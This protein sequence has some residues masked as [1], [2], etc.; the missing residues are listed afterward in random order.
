MSYQY[1]DC[2]VLEIEDMTDRVKRFVF[3]FPRDQ[4]FSFRAGQF[5]MLDLP[6]ESKITNRAYSIASPP[7]LDN[8]FEL[9][10]SF[11]PEGKGT[12]YL[13]NEVREGMFVKA[14]KPLG[15]F[16]LPETLNQEI[17]FICTG[18]GIAP[19]RSMLMDLYSKKIKHQGL[20]L[21]FGNRTEND[22]L[23]RRDFE[24][25]ANAFSGFTFIPVLSRNSPGWT[26]RKGYVHSVYEELFNV[27]RQALFYLCGWAEMLK[28]ARLR[29]EA[30]GY[31][32]HNIKVETYD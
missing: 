1:H 31:P 2:E 25:L 5:V 6:I 12:S 8:T 23:Y 20:T 14:S 15:R 26:G 18:T 7:G 9:V 29:I 19:F 22:I 30:M 11:K 3:S 28:E 4:Q 13:F 24:Q 21:V 27:P 16:I 10:V 32:K 17:C